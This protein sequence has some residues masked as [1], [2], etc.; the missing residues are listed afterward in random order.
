MDAF[1]TEC[2]TIQR[3]YFNDFSKE[4]SDNVTDTNEIDDFD[5]N[6]LSDGD[7]DEYKVECQVRYSVYH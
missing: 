6:L 5:Y 7:W 3:V 4:S 2:E 1:E